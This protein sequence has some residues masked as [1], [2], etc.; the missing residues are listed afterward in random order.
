MP[1]RDVGW[2]DH[3]DYRAI[4]VSVASR[5][6]TSACSRCSSYTASA[7]AYHATCHTCLFHRIGSHAARPRS[8]PASSDNKEYESRENGEA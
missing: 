7:L 8:H 3:G 4:C 5:S 1:V 6:R 2:S